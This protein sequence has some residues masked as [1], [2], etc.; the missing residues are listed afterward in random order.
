M[1]ACPSAT[2]TRQSYVVINVLRIICLLGVAGV[3]SAAVRYDSFASRKG[4]RLV[5]DASVSGGSVLRLTSARR[6][7]AGAVWA[8]EKQPV[9]AGF[10]TTFRF[11][12][13]KQGGLGPG[14]D[15]IAF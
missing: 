12:L 5:G 14:A 2:S 9:A 11:R 7:K 1:R 6:N 8:V 3:A 13:T 15:G 4:L 10:E